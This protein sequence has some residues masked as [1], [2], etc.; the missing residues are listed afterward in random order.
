MGDGNRPTS[1]TTLTQSGGGAFNLVSMDIA[2][3]TLQS[4][5]P[6]RATFTLTGSFATG[7]TITQTYVGFL[8]DALH[9]AT[10]PGF[11]NLISLRF[12]QDN[13][14]TTIPQFDNITVTPV[15]EPASFV[16]LALGGVVAM[17]R[18]RRS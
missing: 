14:A 9:T 8:D 10:F 17:R 16:A 13:S 5:F 12:D 1:T 18:R 6:N 4:Y 7:G 3:L 15:P 11:T 2:R